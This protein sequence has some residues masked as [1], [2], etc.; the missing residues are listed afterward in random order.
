[1]RSRHPGFP[2][3]MGEALGPQWRMFDRNCHIRRG[4][5]AFPGLNPEHDPVNRRNDLSPAC[6]TRLIVKALN[7][8]L[9]RAAF[10]IVVA[11]RRFA[12]DSN[13]KVS[14]QS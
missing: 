11:L 14:N 8:A 12:E 2:A 5:W 10:C 3:F 7:G 1:M 4:I 6:Q 13:L 9:D